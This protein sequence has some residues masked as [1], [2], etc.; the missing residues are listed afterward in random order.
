[1][2]RKSTVI[3]KN[4]E[5]EAAIKTYQSNNNVNSMGFVQI[6]MISKKEQV[7]NQCEVNVCPI[8]YAEK[9]G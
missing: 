5:R 6:K 1:M 2:L 3:F 7:I 8:N 4:Y 9:V